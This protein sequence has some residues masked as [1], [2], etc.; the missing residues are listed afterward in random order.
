MTF[1]EAMHEE[2]LRYEVPVEIIGK[3]D[4]LRYEKKANRDYRILARA[5]SDLATKEKYITQLEFDAMT[6]LYNRTIFDRD[7]SRYMSRADVSS[8]RIGLAI[9][10]ANGLK[11]INDSFGHSEGDRYLKAIAQGIR[12]AARP[13]DRL[14]RLGGDEFA[15]LFD[16]EMRIKDEEVAETEKAIT[17]RLKFSIGNSL[18]SEQFVGSASI[19]VGLSVPN[20]SPDEFF[21]RIDLLMYQAKNI[22][23]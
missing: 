1:Q 22:D 12:G 16:G 13:S 18:N 23:R 5:A 6:G 20:E 19:G 4:D 14:Y 10:D 9:L 11:A 15:V 8:S 17:D 3:W 7:L 21:H 2:P